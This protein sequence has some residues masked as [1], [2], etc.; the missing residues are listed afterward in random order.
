[1]LPFETIPSDD[2]CLQDN[3]ID[4]W[5][6]PLIH[7]PAQADSLLDS[8]EQARAKR[9]YFP[10]H[11]RRF[12]V[13]RAMLRLILSRYLKQD[14]SQLT[15]IYGKHGKP[16]VENS[17]QLEFNLSHSRDLALLAIGRQFPIGIDLEFF[18]PD[19]MMVWPNTPFHPKNYNYFLNSQISLNP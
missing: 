18:H 11:Q 13:A 2:Y 8:T 5:E 14:A 7:P 12:T 17:L 4:I 6:F 3:R 1:M 16:Q 15:F 9:Y 19:L 10:H